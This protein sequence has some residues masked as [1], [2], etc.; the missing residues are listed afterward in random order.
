[1]GL[2]LA[3]AFGGLQSAPKVIA[4]LFVANSVGYFLGDFLNNTLRGKTGMLAWGVAFGL[5]LG[6]GL[7]AALY[8][9]QAPVRA[10]IESFGNKGNNN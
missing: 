8:F 2:I 9:A 1:M 10:R 7:G 5:G 6:A 3:W 4:V